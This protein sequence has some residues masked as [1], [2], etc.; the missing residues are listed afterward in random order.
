MDKYIIVFCEG[1][2]D[3]AFLS[4]ILLI[5]GFRPYDKKVKDFMMPLNELYMS[6][7]RD[8]NIKDSKFKFQSPNIKL[9]YAV[10]KKDTTLVIFHNLGGDGNILNGKANEI[11]ET[12]IEQNDELL[13]ESGEYDKLN[14]RFLYFLDADDVGVNIRLSEVSNKI[15]LDKDLKHYQLVRKKEY[16][17]GCCIFYDNKNP[18]EN[19]K[20]EDLLLDVM[21]N[22]NKTIFEDSLTFIDNNNFLDTRQRKFICT[23]EEE[24]PYGSIQ[25]KKEKSIISIAGQLQFS[26]ASNSVIIANSDYIKKDDILK[27]DVC[28]DIMKLFK[29]D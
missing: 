20:L 19:G 24:K 16:E 27:S 5:H 23:N 10:F 2:H 25:F 9:P 21:Q 15:S 17:V 7:L 8:K 22:N 3:I 13:I 6:V 11:F 14:Y 1:D 28:N 12:Y 29:T 4:R 26:G 18:N